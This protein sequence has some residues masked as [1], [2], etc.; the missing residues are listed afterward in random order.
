LSNTRLIAARKLLD[1]AESGADALI[2]TD[3]INISYISGFTGSTAM[4]LITR[5]ESLFL[6]DFRYTGQARRQC[7]DFTVLD[8]GKSD[9]LGELIADRPSIKRLAF[10]SLNVTV[11]RL[12][13]WRNHIKDINW[14]PVGG[15]ANNLRMIK[16]EREIEIIRHAIAI[17]QDSFALVS[18]MLVEGTTE[19]EFALE[20]E[21]GMRRAGASA[22]AFDIIVAS[23]AN[24]AFPHHRAGERAFEAGDMVTVDWGAKYNGYCSDITRTVMIGGK[25]DD[26]QREIYDIVAKAKELAIESIRPG[27][28]GKE[29]DTI[30]RDY[31]ASFG[32]G[33]YFGH[34]LGHSLGM[35]VHDGA[36]FSQRSDITLAPGM[37]MTV[38]PGIYIEGFG[39]VRL[40]EDVLINETGCEVLT[41]PS[42]PLR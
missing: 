23:G 28:T 3:L 32:Y 25:I 38:E 15:A 7:P 16:D 24:G 31:I 13:G 26:K 36:G 29:I 8:I 22:A 12:D 27:K 2:V 34:S 41:I 10:E 42:G 1:T 19:A 40:E 18:P 35:D 14:V 33:E 39:G 30:A 9:A 17:A 37:I 4:L 11:A 21:F 6:T 20:L 5:D